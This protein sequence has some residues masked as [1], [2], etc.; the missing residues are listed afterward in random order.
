MPGLTIGLLVAA[1]MAQAYRYWRVSTRLQRQQTKWV[2]L[3]LTV[4][5]TSNVVGSV[6]VPW[7]VATPPCSW[8]CWPI[9][10]S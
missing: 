3:G 6:V 1:V 7:L 5:N 10:Y 9:P 4:A 8:C 2:V